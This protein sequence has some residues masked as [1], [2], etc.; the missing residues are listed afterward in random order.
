MGPVAAAAV[1]WI[2][3]FNLD[4]RRVRN[5]WNA[6]TG[7]TIQNSPFWQDFTAH[8]ERRN[9]IA[10]TATVDGTTL[11]TKADA[12]ASI[13]VAQRLSDHIK[14]VLRTNGLRSYA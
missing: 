3:N 9:K 4:E 5:T 8:V 12:D 7:D 10:H 11:P 13:D 14:D 2:W 1:A 6:I